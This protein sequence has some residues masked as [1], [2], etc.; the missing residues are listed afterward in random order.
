M[1]FHPACR[2]DKSEHNT[3]HHFPPSTQV[4]SGFNRS[5]NEA[6]NTQRGTNICSSI[7]PADRINPVTTLNHYPPI[8]AGSER[9]QPF[10]KR[11][12]QHATRHEYLVFHPACRPDKSE[13][14]THH[15]FPPP[16]QVVSGFNRSANEARNTQ[17]DTNICSSIRLADR[18]NPN[19]TPIIISHKRE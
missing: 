4:V 6:C 7:R 1:L 19:T 8:N 12:T 18:I 11:G 14:N 3:H 13:H 10:S 17:R 15:H 16:T 9:F 5:A 2:P